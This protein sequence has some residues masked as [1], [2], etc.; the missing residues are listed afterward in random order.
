MPRPFPCEDD[1]HH[2]LDNPGPPPPLPGRTM[3][4]RYRGTCAETGAAI[5]PGD[6][7]TF[8]RATRRTVLVAK[9]SGQGRRGP[10]HQRRH[11]HQR[12]HLLPQQARPLRRRALLRVLH[13]LK[14]LRLTQLLAFAKIHPV[15]STTHLEP[16]MSNATRVLATAVVIVV[17]L[18]TL[19]SALF[20]LGAAVWFFGSDPSRAMNLWFLGI[21]QLGLSFVLFLATPWASR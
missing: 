6:T 13:D 21:F 8:D 9:A 15:P 10:V 12:R 4:A 5:D 7:I 3:T 11:P 18:A 19:A 17:F 16:V 14:P 20:A 1:E 2:E